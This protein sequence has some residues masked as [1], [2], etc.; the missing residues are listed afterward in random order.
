MRKRARAP[1]IVLL[2]RNAVA[3]G[4]TVRMTGYRMQRVSLPGTITDHDMRTRRLTIL[5]LAALA[6]CGD[7]TGEGLLDGGAIVT[8]AF[9]ATNDTMLVLVTDSATI[10][11]AEDRVATGSGPRM[12]VGPIVRGAG[13]DTRYPFR[14]E[15]EAVRLADVAIEVCDGRPMK[16]AAEVNQFFEWSTGNASA[17]R[18]TWCPWGAKPVAVQRR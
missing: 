2:F 17:P 12:P 5:A 11:H 6:G 13:I 4:A 1:D 15:P 8:F 9:E 3:F 14:F 10:R 7:S 16:S 18:A